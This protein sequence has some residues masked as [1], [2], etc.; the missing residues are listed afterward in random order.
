MFRIIALLVFVILLLAQPVKADYYVT[1]DITGW[2]SKY[3]GFA[4]TQTKVDAVQG[5]DGKIRAL[6][7][8]YKNVDEYKEKEGR[9]WINTQP[10][11]EIGKLINFFNSTNFY[12]KNSK[13]EYEKIKNLETITFPCVKK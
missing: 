3:L 6:A 8:S 4:L 10:R 5:E 9:C 2:S 1:G 12:V 13:G 11:S 7:M